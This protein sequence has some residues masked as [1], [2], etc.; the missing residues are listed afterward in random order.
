MA[1]GRS[2][3]AVH[4]LYPLLASRAAY[5]AGAPLCFTRSGTAG[6]QRYPLHWAGDSQSTWAGFAGTLRGGLSAAW[7]G[8]AHW[9]SD[10]GG[11]YALADWTSGD[12]TICPPPPELY[13]RWMQFGLLCSHSRFHGVTPHEPWAFGDEVIAIARDFWALRDRLRPYLCDCAAEAAATGCPILRPLALEFPDDLASR[14]VDTAYLLGPDVLV[15]PVMSPGGSV[16][17]YLPPGVWRDHWTSEVLEGPVTLRRSNVPLA[18]LP[19]YI[20]DGS[21][22]LSPPR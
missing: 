6:S 3:D 7:S 9:T 5:E 8:F 1:D 19:L 18:Q 20:R 21:H 16:D 2:S 10:I 15:C 13:V 22:P 12:H 11:F 14:H 4:N 17:V